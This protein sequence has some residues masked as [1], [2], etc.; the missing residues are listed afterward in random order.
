MPIGCFVE[1]STKLQQLNDYIFSQLC[2][3]AKEY[4]S[5]KF[6][7]YDPLNPQMQWSLG[8][9]QAKNRVSS[10]DYSFKV[11]SRVNPII[12]IST[13]M[14]WALKCLLTEYSGS[15]SFKRNREKSIFDTMLKKLI[16]DHQLD[17]I[18]PPDFQLILNKYRKIRNNFAHGDWDRIVNIE[19][20]DI[21]DY[22]SNISSLLKYLEIELTNKKHMY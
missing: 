22:I 12:L 19:D 6:D 11:F 16:N 1:I 7:Y 4:E 8:K 9:E 2:S 10:W 13:F 14:E 3:T 20:T 17:V 5:A 18:I 15:D 21:K